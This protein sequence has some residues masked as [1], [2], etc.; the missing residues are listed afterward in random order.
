[1]AQPPAY[2]PADFTSK[3]WNEN[4]LADLDT[5]WAKLKA[6]TDVVRNNLGIIQRDDTKLANRIVHKDA[7]SEEVL[8][9]FA[10][11]W[12]PRGEWA[13]ATEYE[14][15]DAVN[16]G[17]NTYIC[18]TAHTS[19]TFATDLANE[20]WLFVA[21]TQSYSTDA[22]V[23]TAYNNQV[24]VASEAD[25]R[26]LTDT[27]VYRFTPQ[28]LSQAARPKL[29]SLDH[30]DLPLTLTG[31]DY[32]KLYVVDLSAAT[33]DETITL[34]AEGTAGEGWNVRIRLTGLSSGNKLIINNDGA[35]AE[36][37][38][39]VPGQLI[40]P[41]TDGTSWF[42]AETGAILADTWI[43]SSTTHNYA[44]GAVYA[45][46]DITAG[47][48]GGGGGSE[49][50]DRSGA[51]G[52]GGE[53]RRVRISGFDSS[54]TVT[55]G[56][57]GSGGAANSG[58]SAGSNSSWGSFATAIAGGGG[59]AAFITGGD[60]GTGGSGGQGL[61]GGGGVGGA[62]TEGAAGGAGGASFQGAGGAAP[63]AGSAGNDGIQ[64]GGGTGGGENDGAGGA[65]GD[66]IAHC[67]E[68]A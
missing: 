24:P 58:G 37:E 46:V 52:G 14:K 50:S 65:G 36:W 41:V 53:T 21:A 12:N 67:V 61:P 39:S 6:H 11:S 10:A 23:E 31:D 44:A 2:S 57:G 16:E 1:M 17:G 18:V 4:R 3:E 13:T 40:H 54:E 49:S 62:G 9:L 34:P 43:T 27:T 29:T 60:G 51:G 42:N 68:Y 15:L 45:D 56:A 20:L 64:G 66:G 33:G 48:G 30:T 8:A 25:A 19:G 59:T 55:I 28:R 5:E 7:M 32:G 22:E 38:M 26:D 35:T 63:S 47:G